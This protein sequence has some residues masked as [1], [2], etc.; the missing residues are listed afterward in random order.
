MAHQQARVGHS[1]RDDP[2]GVDY[3]TL[4]PVD[5]PR[6][7]TRISVDGTTPSG[8]FVLR[9]LSLVDTRT[10]TTRQVTLST[11][12][13]YRLVHSGDVKIYQNLD[14]LPRAFVVHQAEVIPDDDQ[15]VARLRDPAFDPAQTIVVDGGEPLVAEG[16]G[17]AEIIRYAPEEVVVDVTTDVTAYLLLTDTFYPGWRVTVDGR[18]ADILRADLA[19]RAV[20]LEPGAHRVEFLY[21]PASVRWGAWVSGAALLLWLVGLVWAVL[22]REPD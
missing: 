10:T 17:W 2:S 9:G 21:R 6:R 11:D 1:W 20:P 3:V 18:P 12:G 5:A 4:I 13:N 22:K 7:L 15:A 19:F 16:T 8:E 14:A